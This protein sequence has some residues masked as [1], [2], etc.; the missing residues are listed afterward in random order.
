MF[1]K[2][3]QKKRHAAFTLVELI[4]AAS[5]LAILTTIWFYSYTWNIASARDSVRQTDISA[6]NSQLKLYKRERWSYPFPGDSFEIQ[7]RGENVALQGFMNQNVSLTTADILPT[8]PDL[9]L[10]YFYSTTSNRQEFQLS[11]SMEWEWT[12]YALLSGDYTSV[13][14]DLLPNIMLAQSSTTPIEINPANWWSPNQSSFIFHKWLRSL[15]Y[16]F[17]SWNPVYDTTI[18][19]TQLLD[20]AR[21]NY[22]QNSDYRD[23]WEIA[24]AG[25]RI[26]PNGQND[27][28]QVLNDS[29]VLIDQA[30]SCS[31]TGCIEL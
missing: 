17:E 11:A 30:C 4:V 13:A 10:A 19:L 28:Y 14:K 2:Q 29:W 18:T 21:D 7:N 31:S 26:T 6:L 24:R 20:E 22:W 3:A 16:D 27:T 25:K 15:P 1:Y 9:E 23:C 5:I 12:P 8:D